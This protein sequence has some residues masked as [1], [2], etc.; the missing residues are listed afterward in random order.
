MGS[1]TSVPMEPEEAVLVDGC[2]RGTALMRVLLPLSL[3]EALEGVMVSSVLRTGTCNDLKVLLVEESVMEIIIKAGE[4]VRELRIK[5]I[6]SVQGT[7]E[8]VEV[9]KLP[10]TYTPHF[11][12]V[13]NSVLVDANDLPSNH[14]GFGVNN[15]CSSEERRNPANQLTRSARRYLDVAMESNL[16]SARWA[17]FDGIEIALIWMLRIISPADSRK[18]L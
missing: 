3:V 10:I 4:L 11:T 1:V 2:H 5:E 15:Y 8:W 17:Q 6:F 12:G 18:G 13:K 16:A 7:C 14:Y 9:K